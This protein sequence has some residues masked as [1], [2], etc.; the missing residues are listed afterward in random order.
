M[1][2]MD[3][4]IA[5]ESIKKHTK[6]ILFIIFCVVLF[7]INVYFNLKS[8]IYYVMLPIFKSKNLF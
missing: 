1:S 4:L 5:L 2:R 3:T 7:A 6:K 8:I